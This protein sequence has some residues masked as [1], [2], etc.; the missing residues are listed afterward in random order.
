FRAALRLFFITVN[1][2]MGLGPRNAREGDLICCFYGGPMLYVL[3]RTED[4]EESYRIIGDCYVHGLMNGESL[5]W[6]VPRQHFRI[7]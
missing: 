3:R 4:A 1:G 7:V 5:K 2:Y 6:D